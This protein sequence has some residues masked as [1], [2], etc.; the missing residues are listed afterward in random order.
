MRGALQP[1]EGPLL[2][3]EMA[4]SLLCP[5]VLPKASRSPVSA[6]HEVIRTQA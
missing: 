3:L 5:L 1:R 6:P 4:P 2:C